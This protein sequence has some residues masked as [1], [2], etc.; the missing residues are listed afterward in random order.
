VKA[1]RTLAA[2]AAAIA[3][4]AA[5]VVAVVAATRP[6][7][8]PA[9]IGGELGPYRGSEPPAG[10]RAADFTLRDFRGRVV[11][12]RAQRG[13]VVVLSF[14]DTK[15]TESCPI[16]TSVMGQA[17]RSL[18][19]SQRRQVVPIL[20][21]VS[22]DDDTPQNVQRFLARRNAL[23]LEYLIGTT[24]QL[25]P[26]WKAYGVVSAVDTGS[27]DIH[28]AGVRVFD[29]R[30]IWVSTQHAGVDLTAANLA[31]DAATALERS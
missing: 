4:A 6:G 7:A 12:M 22:P 23:A 29:R 17:Y 20:I 21:T 14:V 9:P 15:C 3:V 1:P 18:P 19:V 5:V 2:L 10:I 11:S 25:R 13:K 31:T 24:R 27:V 28:S 30:G 16:V 26:V 8:S